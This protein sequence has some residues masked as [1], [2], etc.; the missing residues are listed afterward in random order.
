MGEDEEII[1]KE[2]LEILAC[3]FCKGD[4]RLE[5]SELVGACG[6][7]YKIEDGIPHMLY[8]ICPECKIET[9]MTK[10]NDEFEFVCDKCGKSL[11]DRRER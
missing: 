1:S 4:I 3:P 6:L 11:Q 10:E 2:L 7:R 8:P 9:R 5:G